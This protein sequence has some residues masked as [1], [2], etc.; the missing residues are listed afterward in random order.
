MHDLRARADNLRQ[1]L[2]PRGGA[3]APEDR[4]K[5]LATVPRSDNEEL[6]VSWD[7]Y[8][9]RPFL[10]I[11]L[12]RRGEGGW[13]PA[14]DKGIT[15]RLRELADLAEGVAAA[16]E[17]AEAHQAARQQ[18]GGRHP[19]GRAQQRHGGQQDSRREAVQGW[20]Q[21]PRQGSEPEWMAD[22]G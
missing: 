6:R 14:K 5:R 2:A 16:L 22:R 3:Q 15:V 20:A 9:G 12:W 19:G 18:E 11:R 7:S 4:G 1:S 13:W 10:S 17:L 21:Q 8:E